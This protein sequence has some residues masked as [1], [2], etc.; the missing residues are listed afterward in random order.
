ML[1]DQ[2]TNWPSWLKV[3]HIN[4]GLEAF[5]LGEILWQYH[6]TAIYCFERHLCQ[7]KLTYKL[8]RLRKLCKNFAIQ[9]I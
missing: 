3:G 5:W 9:L 2:L 7:S 4:T 6:L 8:C 1:V